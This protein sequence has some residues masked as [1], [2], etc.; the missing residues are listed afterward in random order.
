MFT[1]FAQ[2]G[3][4][5]DIDRVFGRISSTIQIIPLNEQHRD[6]NELI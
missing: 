5:L 6:S 4:V 2:G 3:E 1:P